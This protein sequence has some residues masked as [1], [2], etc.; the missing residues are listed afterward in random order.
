MA[1]NTEISRIANTARINSDTLI[2]AALTYEGTRDERELRAGRAIDRL[3]N[4]HLD[5]IDV[6]NSYGAHTIHAGAVLACVPAVV[7]LI[8]HDQVSRN[9]AVRTTERLMDFV[10]SLE[11][12]KAFERSNTFAGSKLAEIAVAACTWWSA[13]N[14]RKDGDY[15]LLTDT[16]RDRSSPGTLRNGYDVIGKLSGGRVKF[17][18]K[19]GNSRIEEEKL[20]YVQGISIVSPQS[21]CPTSSSSGSTLTILRDFTNG[22]SNMDEYARVLEEFSRPSLKKS[23]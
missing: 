1:R 6:N 7:G 3:E 12:R 10:G 16:A 22:N 2:S 5:L 13:I 15:A 19:K 17:Q 21:L 4:L 20:R 8:G 9:A 14:T 11:K 18:V 23:A